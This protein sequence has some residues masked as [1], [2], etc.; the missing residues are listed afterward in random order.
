MT[1]TSGTPAP[2]P[3]RP[4]PTPPSAAIFALAAA[5]LA[6]VA[7]SAS[8]ALAVPAPKGAPPRAAEAV[9]PDWRNWNDGLRQAGATKKPVI[10]DV[11]TDWC[12]WCRRMDHDVY[13]RAEIAN[14][15]RKN[16][17]TVRLNAESNDAAR[18]ENRD[19]TSRDLSQRFR[20]SG[21]PTTIFLRANGEHMAN[22]PGYVPAD[23]F[24][25]LLRYVAEGYADRNVPFAEF[26]KTAGAQD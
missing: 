5:A 6:A 8:A 17:V 14:Y 3:R 26:E 25:L 13:A 20:V 2:R 12:G 15:L 23:R 19:W 9:A 11:Y 1:R 22:V 10:V 7:I 21:Y 16:Y 24:L 18:Y 4:A